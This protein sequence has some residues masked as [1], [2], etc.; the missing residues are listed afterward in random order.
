M[1]GLVSLFGKVRTPDPCWIRIK[2]KPFLSLLRISAPVY[3]AKAPS[4][5]IQTL[6]KGSTK[7]VRPY[8]VTAVLRD[9][10]L[11]QVAYDSLIELQ[12]K[13][14]HNICRKRSLVAIGVHDLD[15]LAPPF[16]YS[17]EPQADITFKPLNQEKDFRVD[18][19]LVFY[20]NS[21]HLK[22]YL[23]ITK[24]EPLHPVIRDSNGVVVSLPPIINGDHSKLTMN[25]KNIFIECTATDLTK[26]NIVLDILVTMI[27]E[28]SKE[29]FVAEETSVLNEATGEEKKYPSLGYRK[30]T[31]EVE[32]VNALIGIE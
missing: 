20:Q 21:P 1:Q 9:V 27:G 13:L 17:A 7:G 15:K 2:D 19:L 10:T 23:H 12:E 22:H 14:H 3:K 11:D 16:I 24:D 4:N 18:E 5:R 32:S 6:V 30:E 29:K 26:A 8:I 31:L 25:T 28:H